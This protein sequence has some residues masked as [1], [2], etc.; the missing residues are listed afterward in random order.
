M[1]IALFYVFLCG[2]FVLLGWLFGLDHASF[3]SVW[4]YLIILGDFI[5]SFVLAFASILGLLGFVGLFRKGKPFDNKMNHNFANA[6]LRFVLHMARIK[7]KVTG[8]ENIPKDNK[9]VFV[10]NHQENF[11]I[12]VLMPTFK[13]HPICFI[14]KEPLFKVPIIGKW[15]GLLGNVSIG[16]NADR[17]AAK[18]IITAI[19]RYKD[20]VP[21]GVFPEGQRAR[22]NELI[23]FKPGAFKLAMK[24]K[25]NILIGTIY[26]MHTIFSKFPW[27]RYVVKVHF[28][29][30]LPYEEYKDLNSQE[31]SAHV[32]GVIQAKLDHYKNAQ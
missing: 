30:L 7:T 20:G 10:C 23:E 16:K 29:P 15:I 24:P 6:F 5:L 27:K 9:F 2:F 14:A 22:G 17:E 12:P 26:D 31:L 11:D 32:K 25:A 13:D 18:S 4:T 1:L 3:T 21:F 8:L 19:K 28:H